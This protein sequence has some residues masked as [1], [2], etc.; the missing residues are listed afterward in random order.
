MVFVN[1]RLRG[2]GFL[3]DVVLWTPDKRYP[4]FRLTETTQSMPWLAPE[5]WAMLTCDIG[6]MV[7]DRVW[8]MSDA[9]LA[10]WC[11]EHLDE[12]IPNVR[13]RYDGCRVVRTPMAYPI[14][15]RSYEPERQAFERSTGIAGLVSVG[16]NG[17]FAHN[18]MEDVYWRTRRRL[19]GLCAELAIPS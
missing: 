15:H 5:G 2:R 6:C 18:L 3:P 13:E 14:F 17:E 8:T 9:D 11:L 1:L 10:A 19:Q 4:F 16:R 7:G 12:F